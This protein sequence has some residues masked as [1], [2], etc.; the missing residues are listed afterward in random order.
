MPLPLLPPSSSACHHGHDGRRCITE[1]HTPHAMLLLVLPVLVLPL[2]ALPL[3]LLVLLPPP[4]FLS[5]PPPS[6][7]R[8]TN[9]RGPRV[10]GHCTHLATTLEH[11]DRQRGLLLYGKGVP[12]GAQI[13]QT[14]DVHL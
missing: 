13:L 5:R 12:R 8:A 2:L 9:T 11:G 4:R 10:C 14:C 7:S 6:R 3:V 1:A